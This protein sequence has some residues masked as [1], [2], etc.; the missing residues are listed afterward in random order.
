MPGTRRVHGGAL[1]VVALGVLLAGAPALA[2]PVVVLRS[3]AIAAYDTVAAAFE[4]SH[5]GPVAGFA[6]DDRDLAQR[7]A[8]L[9]PEAV[10]AIGLRAALFA[11][12]HVPRTPIV[13]C[14]VQEAARGELS[15][16][17]ITGV[18]I[19]IAPT[20]EFAAWRK[21]APRVRRVAM[22][23]GEASVAEI[24]RWTQ[25]AAGRGIE[26]VDVPIDDLSQLATRA[27]EVAPRVDAF[28]MP[29]DPAVAAGEAFQFLLRLSLD[30]RK[31]L[32][33]FS[34]ALVRAGAVAALAPD[35]AA[36][37]AQ[38]AEAVRRIQAG[39][40]AGDIPVRAVRRTHVVVNEATA[41]ALGL[42]L[43][44]ELRRDVEVLR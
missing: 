4:S 33:V 38:A 28:W 7:I 11:R 12:D 32:F 20:A 22:F 8:A 21:V 41:R 35:Y 9:E 17:W 16:E 36:A 25:E 42:E 19:D 5:E 44:R 13:F 40:R 26:L 6:L 23:R 15:G 31:P 37:G 30:Q 18:T 14:A 34:D 27:R 43:S 3:R 2:G 10:V 29:A 1:G 24:A 39:E